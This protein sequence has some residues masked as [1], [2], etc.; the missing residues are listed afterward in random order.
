MGAVVR[1]CG[2]CIGAVVRG[3]GAYISAIDV[4]CRFETS[5]KPA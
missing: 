3:C 2:N 5:P 1:G 4:R